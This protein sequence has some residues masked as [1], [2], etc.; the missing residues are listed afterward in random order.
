MRQAYSRERLVSRRRR[1]PFE[2]PLLPAFARAVDS[3]TAALSSGTARAYNTTV[4][5]F[6]G[7]LATH[8]PEVNR[9]ASSLVNQTNALFRWL[10]RRVVQV[11]WSAGFMSFEQVTISM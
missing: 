1:P 5:Q 4:R 8:H 7:Y 3:L 9:R 2:H 10:R 6:L 11:F